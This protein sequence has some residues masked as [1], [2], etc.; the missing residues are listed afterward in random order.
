MASVLGPMCPDLPECVFVEECEVAFAD[1][2]T[3]TDSYTASV[4]TIAARVGKKDQPQIPYELVYNELRKNRELMRLAFHSRPAIA[5][6]ILKTGLKMYVQH[7]WAMY[8]ALDTK[9]VTQ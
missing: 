2:L 7:E 8:Q 5:D 1:M 6:Y 4:N 3:L 9:T